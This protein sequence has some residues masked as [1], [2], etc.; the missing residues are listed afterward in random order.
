VKPYF[1]RTDVDARFHAEHLRDRLP[2][3]IFDAHVHMNLPQ[4]V[5][6]VPRERVLSD[7][8]MECGY[9]LPVE[10]ALLCAAE[11]FPGIDY[12]IAGFPFP[13]REAHLEE[14]NLYL[15]QKQSQ[16]LIRAFMCVRPEWDPEE[17]ERQLVENDF[18]GFKPYPDMVA[19]SKGA[20][21]SIPEY[22]PPHQWEILDRHGKAVMLH[23]PR[24]GRLADDD[25]VRELKELRQ[26]Y[27][28]VTIIIAHFGRSFCPIYLSDGLRKLGD[29]SGFHFDTSGVI[30]PA[31]YDIA[32]TRI[33]PERIL[34]GTD[35]PTFF[36]HGK[37]EWTETSYINLAREPFSWNRN[38]KDPATEATYTLFLYEQ[39][40]SILD[41]MDRH[42]FSA[43]QKAAVFHDN[44]FRILGSA[45]K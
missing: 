21:I 17:V 34:F 31:V 44:A 40:R 14:S 15:A 26:R 43:A 37:R 9:I 41:A 25:N 33:D 1:E 13:I 24:A 38:H 19:G 28:R 8:A 22:I 18:A 11:L 7:W 32:F 39:A 12:S 27:P 4:H 16:G 10:D 2:R 20:P 3:R 23:I 29:A 36:W 30:N 45:R 35:M 6:D 5:R 42:H